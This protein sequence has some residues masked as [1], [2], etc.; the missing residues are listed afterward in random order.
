MS[1]NISC[2]IWGAG[3]GGLRIYNTVKDNYN[4]LGFVDSDTQKWGTQTVDGLKISDPNILKTAEYE[5]IILGTMMG[6]NEVPKILENMGLS[7]DLLITEYAS[8]S[9]N[10]R[11]LFLK[12]ISE[13]INGK[14]L[15]G[16]VAEVGVYKGEFAKEINYFFENRKCFLFDTFEGFDERD[17]S[18]EA[19]KSLIKSEHF[20]QTAPELVLGKMPYKENIV[21]K[22]GYFP[23]TVEGIED[24]FVFVNL[25]CDLYKPTLEGLRYFWNR[26]PVGGC[27]LIH[28]YFGEGFPNVKKA[29]SDFQ[30]EIGL[31]LACLP[32][33]DDL[34]IAIYKYC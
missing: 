12:R 19:E 14:D 34:S 25:D 8:L 18:Y 3:G 2:Y 28:D 10:A 26:M 16:A 4:I 15:E 29:V 30:M 24:N 5:K 22:K 27:I 6:I 17:F 13:M 9:V 7:K 33:G 20:K 31:E 11:R 1:N 23:D 21:I 32:V